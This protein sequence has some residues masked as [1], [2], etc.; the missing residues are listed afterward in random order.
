M[1]LIFSTSDY[2]NSRL[3]DEHGHVLYTIDTPTSLNKKT[4][5]S[6]HNRDR[7]SEVIAG[8][9]LEALQSISGVGRRQGTRFSREGCG[10]R[11]FTFFYGLYGR[12]WRGA[13]ADNLSSSQSFVGSDGRKYKWKIESTNCWLKA[14]NSVVELAKYHRCNLGFLTPQH[15]PYIEISPSVLHILD[16]IIMTFVYA[17]KLSQDRRRRP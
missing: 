9:G 15:P 8:I 3:F 6:K 5:I 4:T 11:M 12:L 14:E 10:L 17:E 16:E 2:R 7:S 13:D 1:Q